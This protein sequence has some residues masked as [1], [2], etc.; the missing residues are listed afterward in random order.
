MKKALIL[1]LDPF[2]YLDILY[3]KKR[4]KMNNH[5]LVVIVSCAV[6]YEIK[7]KSTSDDHCT[8]NE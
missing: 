4:K 8:N 3:L 5:Y 6:I 2:V 1:A 7:D